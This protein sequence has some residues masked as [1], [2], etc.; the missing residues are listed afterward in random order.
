MNR[1]TWKRDNS[2][3]RPDQE[4]RLSWVAT[5]T[6]SNGRT[7]AQHFFISEADVAE[8]IKNE[9]R[10]RLPESGIERTVR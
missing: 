2:S 5:W 1:V 4:G 8:R 10:D 3:Q 9:E 7:R 6:D